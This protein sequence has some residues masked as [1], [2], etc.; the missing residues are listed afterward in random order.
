MKPR[1]LLL[2]L[3]LSFPP[4]ALAVERGFDPKAGTD[5]LHILDLKRAADI[6]PSSAQAHNDLGIACAEAEKPYEA[7]AEFEKARRLAPEDAAITF[8]LGVA[9][10]RAK[11]YTDALKYLGRAV[12]LHPDNAAALFNM[13]IIHLDMGMPAAAAAELERALI[14]S[15]G[16]PLVHYNLAVAHE[17]DEKG[18]R[19]GPDF[20][21]ATA[22]EHYRLAIEGGLDNVAVR[23]NMGIVSSKTGDYQTAAADLTRAAEFDPDFVP[24]RRELAL[25]LL[26][27]GKYHRALSELERAMAASD[28]PELALAAALAHRGL[29]SLYLENGDYKRAMGEFERAL[30]H[31][32]E[33][34]AT[35]R[36]MARIETVMGDYDAALRR[37]KAAAELDPGTDL[38]EQLSKVHF[39]RGAGFEED[40]RYRRA[41]AEY[42]RAVSI[43]EDFALALLAMGE[44]CADKLEM[45]EEAVR[46]L[47]RCLDLEPEGSCSRHA[48]EKLKALTDSPPEEE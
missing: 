48:A 15:P 21:A 30:R 9:H 22:L 45:R 3:L 7:I 25:A 31:N 40:G 20:P 38:D 33:D 34:A 36:E 27:A 29:G 17:H 41:L 16:H 19:Y 6:Q 14:L 1:L 43:R 47:R 13:G 12:S 26:R 23:Y 44:L 35:Y 32:G 37:L 2:I 5:G 8:N 28:D 42:R 11:N 10:A 24:A 18:T 39:L 46:C 4:R